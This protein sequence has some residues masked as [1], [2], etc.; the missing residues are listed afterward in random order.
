MKRKP[1]VHFAF[2]EDQWRIIHEADGARPR[3][4]GPRALRAETYFFRQRVLVEMVQ[5]V[6]FAKGIGRTTPSNQATLLVGGARW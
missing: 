2:R 5:F 4:P 6:A 1:G 3:P